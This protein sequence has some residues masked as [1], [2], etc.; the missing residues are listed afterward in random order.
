MVSPA[1]A[2]AL[3]V[4]LKCKVY[5]WCCSG[6]KVFYAAAREGKIMECYVINRFHQ[7]KITVLP[8]AFAV[9]LVMAEFHPN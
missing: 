5:L 7:N 6:L 3:T 1:T 9:M 8:A 2:V 4:P